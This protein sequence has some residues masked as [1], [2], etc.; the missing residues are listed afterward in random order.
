MAE[1]EYPKNLDMAL[2]GPKLSLC[3]VV[4]SVWGVIQLVR[5]RTKHIGS[6]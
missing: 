3:G 1:A 4:L 5:E 6:C 2:C